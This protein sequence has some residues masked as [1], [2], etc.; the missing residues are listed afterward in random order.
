MQRYTDAMKPLVRV[1]VVLL[2]LTCG[3]AHAQFVVN[4]VDV[5]RMDEGIRVRVDLDLNL[6]DAVEQ[7]LSNGVPLIVIHEIELQKKGWFWNHVEQQRSEKHRLRYYA[8]SGQYVID[9]DE[10]VLDVFR[11]AADALETISSAATTFDMPAQIDG[12]TVAVRSRIDI[13]ALPAPLRPTALFSP[14]WQLSS[15][16]SRWPI[17]GLLTN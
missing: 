13:N 4:K 17:D 5:Q 3:T 11:S 16:W 7:A 15:D 10:S 12:Y 9:S 6:T 2:T 1:A 14:Q 8:L